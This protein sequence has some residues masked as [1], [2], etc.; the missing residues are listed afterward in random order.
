M[1]ESQILAFKDCS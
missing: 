1:E